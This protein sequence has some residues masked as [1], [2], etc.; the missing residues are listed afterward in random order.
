MTHEE[1][2]NVQHAAHAVD[3]LLTC[4]TSLNMLSG[5][6]CA[7]QT[8][9]VSCMPLNASQCKR[10]LRCPSAQCTMRMAYTGTL[11]SSFAASCCGL[12][13][14]APKRRNLPAAPIS[15]TSTAL[16]CHRLEL[17]H[18]ARLTTNTHA[19]RYLDTRRVSAAPSGRLLTCPNIQSS[20]N[21]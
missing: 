2:E 6:P 8:L 13:L 16:P 14:F 18:P 12:A 11:I 4:S 3:N 15:C 19:L 9:D 7:G 17:K 10:E 1:K 21:V 5:L 20:A